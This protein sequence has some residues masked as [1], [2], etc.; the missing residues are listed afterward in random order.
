[1]VMHKYMLHATGMLMVIVA[2]TFFPRITFAEDTLQLS[3]T[4]GKPPMTVRVTGPKQLL[5]KANGRFSKEGGCGYT[6]DWA[7][8]P[9]VTWPRGPVGEDCAEGMQ[10]TYVQEGIYTV[11]AAIYHPGPA[12]APVT[13]WKGSIEMRVVK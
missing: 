12:G 8:L 2:I 11:N 13:D 5:E 9:G 10:H 6:I 1:M 7:D 3:A 4:N